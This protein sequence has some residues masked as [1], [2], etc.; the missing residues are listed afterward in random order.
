MKKSLGN[1]KHHL[2]SSRRAFLINALKAG[3][4]GLGTSGHLAQAAFLSRS[5][6]KLKQG[7][8]FYKIK[9]QVKINGQLANMKS[10]VKDND[11]VETVGNSKAIFVVGQDA[12]LLQA[13][14]KL[15]LQAKKKTNRKINP[16]QSTIDSR[17][18]INEG[19]IV[20][21]LRLI[22]GAVLTVFGKTS[23]TLKTPN[24]SIGIR[25]TGVY[26]EVEADRTY[27]CTCYGTVDIASSIDS[28]SKET[29]QTNHHESPRYIYSQGEDGKLIQPAKV[30]NHSDLELTIL[31]EL[32]G[33]EPP[34]LEDGVSY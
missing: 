8:S 23:H 4:F 25:G 29:V 18:N 16:S 13:N 21:T 3:L 15:Q 11:R 17:T 32:V 2:I 19:M 5:Y 22:T 26:A 6:G 27:L 1:K 7:K 30:K 28:T 34:F 31:E 12:F 20:D 9:G 33:R 24:A 10:I 14:T